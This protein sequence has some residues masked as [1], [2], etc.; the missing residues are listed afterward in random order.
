MYFEKFDNFHI[1]H[2]IVEK[3][4]ILENKDPGL[5]RTLEDPRGHRTLGDPGNL[6]RRQLYLL[7]ENIL[8]CKMLIR[9]NVRS[10]ESI[11]CITNLLILNEKDL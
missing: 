5:W 3:L 4:G 11:N 1:I 2:F 10:I 8:Q 7:K 9:L 6:D